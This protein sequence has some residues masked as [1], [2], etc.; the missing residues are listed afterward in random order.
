MDKQIVTDPVCAM[1]FEKG[2]AL[3]SSTYKGR[4]YYFCSH[5]CKDR[6]DR[7]FDKEKFISQ[8]PEDER[9]GD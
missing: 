2:K 9:Q 7:E 6:F 5:M 4:T 1:K 3:A 8:L